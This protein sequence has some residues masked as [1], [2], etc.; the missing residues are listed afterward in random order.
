MIIDTHTHLYS[1]EFNT[2][3]DTP[4]TAV[5]RAVTA[6]VAHMILPNIDLQS[7][8]PMRKLHTSRPNVT[9][10]AMGL[11]PT[12][13]KDSWREDLENVHAHLTDYLSDWIA[14][15]EIGLDL[16]WDKSFESQQ[17]QALDTQLSWAEEY[18]LPV[19]IHC[20]EALDN[21]LEV[22]SDHRKLTGVF[23]SFSGTDKDVDK[24]RAKVGDFYF[25]INGIVTF[26]RNT[27]TRAIPA[28]GSYRLLL[29]TDSPYLAPV[30][31]RGKRN[32]SSFIVHTAGAIANA[33]SC[34]ASD[35]AEITTANACNLFNIRI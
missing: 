22:I 31:M 6:G 17:M 5:D 27:L 11:H 4:E 23:H 16:Y 29:E 12:E 35:I 9:S 15:G 7:I 10:M 8:E 14:I 28:I 34:T 33:L 18:S 24:I 19:I 13:I 26:K 3:T 30:P 25:G 2:D 20:R 32:E 1:E 21:I